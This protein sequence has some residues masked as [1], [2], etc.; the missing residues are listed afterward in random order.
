[1]TF[2]KKGGLSEL[3]VNYDVAYGET[4]RI[5]IFP[6]RMDLWQKVPWVS[7]KPAEHYRHNSRNKALY[8]F[9]LQI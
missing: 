5:G 2:V 4:L 1:M 8:V 9:V 6:E 3:L 7:E